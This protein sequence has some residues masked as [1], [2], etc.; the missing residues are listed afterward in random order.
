M[1]Q[2]DSKMITDK[3]LIEAHCDGDHEA[4]AELVH[5]HGGNVL[6]YLTKMCN[7]RDKAEDFFQET[8]K[9]VHEKAHTLQTRQ[10]KS[11]LFKIAT[12]VALDGFR[13]ESRVRTISMNQ[14]NN[15]QKRSDEIN[16]ITFKDNS[17]EPSKEAVK[18]ELREQV[19]EAISKLPKHQRSTLILAYYQQLSYKEVAQA[20][21][22]SLGTVKTQMFRALRTLAQQLPVVAGEFE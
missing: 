17:S 12:N 11:W 10:F 8:F 22:C 9:R 16:E 5:R 2:I 6:G 20:M 15:C 18:S 19:R 13:K 14:N 7:D 4:F 3:E 21:N 1:E